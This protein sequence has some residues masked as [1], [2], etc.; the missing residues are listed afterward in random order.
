MVDRSYE[1][2]L[3]VITGSCMGSKV[4]WMLLLQYS[5]LRVEEETSIY[6]VNE[7]IRDLSRLVISRVRKSKD[8][9]QLSNLTLKVCED[10]LVA[11]VGFDLTHR[12]QLQF[13][14]HFIQVSL[15]ITL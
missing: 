6:H 7:M 4:I 14:R 2:P 1:C 8:R 11:F 15:L 5:H 12:P 13:S 3:R 10:L 9:P